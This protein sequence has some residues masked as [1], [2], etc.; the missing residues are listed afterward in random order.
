MCE[1]GGKWCKKGKAGFTEQC[2]SISTL[3]D[4]V[5]RGNGNIFQVVYPSIDLSSMQQLRD[6]LARAVAMTQHPEWPYN[7]FTRNCQHWSSFVTLGKA[8]FTHLSPSAC[9][10]E[11]KPVELPHCPSCEGKTC[12]MVSFT[13]DGRICTSRVFEGLRGKYCFTAP[14]APPSHRGTT[15]HAARSERWGRV[16]T[17]RL[18]RYACEASRKRG[19]GPVKIHDCLNV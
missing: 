9:V 11:N 6:Q 8:Q 3:K 15:D 16:D 1:V 14:S 2:L 7:P 10:H 4:F 17:K 18:P 13:T 19:N 5:V 12:R